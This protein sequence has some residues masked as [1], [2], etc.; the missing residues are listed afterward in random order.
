MKGSLDDL[1]VEWNEALSNDD[2]RTG[3]IIALK[4][5]ELSIENKDKLH[6]SEFFHF[7]KLAINRID[8]EIEEKPRDEGNTCSF[9]SNNT[10][11]RFVVRG[12][13]VAICEECIR[14]ASGLLRDTST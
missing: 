12:P 6:E 10:E 3:L 14:T 7:A 9:C 2:M 11:D 4:G 13:G 1:V 5:Y 8:H